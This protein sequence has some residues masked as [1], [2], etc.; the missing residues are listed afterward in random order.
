MGE[1][2]SE[3]EAM[4]AHRRQHVVKK[5]AKLKGSIKKEKEH[6]LEDLKVLENVAKS[7]AEKPLLPCTIDFVSSS[8][9]MTRKNGG[10]SV[11]GGIRVLVSVAGPFLFPARRKHPTGSLSG[12]CFVSSPCVSVGREQVARGQTRSPCVCNSSG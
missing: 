3:E 2:Q 1:F 7:A 4:K 12:F 11:K 10:I 8:Q 5:F 6:R 9:H